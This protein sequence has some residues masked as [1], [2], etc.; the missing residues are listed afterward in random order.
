M[1]TKPTIYGKGINDAGYPTEQRINGI[2]VLCPFYTKWSSMIRRC[3]S[4]E[5]EQYINCNVCEEWLT[6]SIFK[7]W[8]LQQDWEGLELDKDIKIP[9][10]KMYSPFTCL[11]VPK[12][13]NNLMKAPKDRLL[14]IGISAHQNSYLVRCK[15]KGEF[16]IRKTF[17]D[18]AK[19]KLAYCK[20]KVELIHKAAAEVKELVKSFMLA[21]DLDTVIRNLKDK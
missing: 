19:A 9:G 3:Y 20:A 12:E 14:P 17:K 1:N 2:R 21:W 13:V 7:E 8:M 4:G 11:F 16:L 15:Y 6:F 10:N 18:L 5:H